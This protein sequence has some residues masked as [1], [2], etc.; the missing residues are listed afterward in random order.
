MKR[1]KLPKQKYQCMNPLHKDKRRYFYAEK[2]PAKVLV[3]DIETLPGWKRFWQLGE[4]DWSPKSIIH[5]WVVLSISWKWLFEPKSYSMVMTSREALARN[6]KRLVEKTYELFNEAAIII[7]HNGD[8]FDIPK[9]NFRFLQYGMKPP[10]PFLTIDTLTA[11][12]KQFSTSS[13]KLAYISEVLGL[14]AKLPTDYD[15]WVRCER[16]DK[17]ALEYMREYNEQDIWTLE[18]VYVVLR[19]WIKHPNM[20]LYMLVDK[21]EAVCPHC[22]SDELDWGYFHRTPAR[23]YKACRCGNCGAIGRDAKSFIATTVARVRV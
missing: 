14:P 12:K 3:F 8:S 20:G 19:P 10:S 22:G 11:F 6:D 5:D 1:G 7:A 4:Q 23:V 17:E 16:G 15:L 9:M 21:G 2:S 13:N 18:D